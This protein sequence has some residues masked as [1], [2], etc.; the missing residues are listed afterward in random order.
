MIICNMSL[1]VSVSTAVSKLNRRVP[2]MQP[3]FEAISN[4]LEAGATNIDVDFESAADTQMSIEGEETLCNPKK[5]TGFTITYDGAGFDSRNIKAFTELWTRNKFDLGCK[6]IGR[7]TWLKVYENI[8]I[9]SET[10]EGRTEI[11][12]TKSF[13]PG[14]D[15]K[16][17]QLENRS[18]SA[19]STRISFSGITTD[20]YKPQTSKSPEVDKR[21][22]AELEH[23]HSLVENHLLLKLILLKKEGRSFNI[24][25]RLNTETV[26]ISD[27]NIPILTEEDFSIQNAS[28]IDVSFALHYGFFDNG[29]NRQY[30]YYC[31]N[32]RAVKSFRNNIGITGFP[33]KE[34]AIML[35]VS[36]YLDENV[37]DERNG[38]YFE[39]DKDGEPILGIDTIE[40]V[41]KPRVSKLI[42]DKFPTITKAFE[43]IKAAAIE[44]VPY[45]ASII[46]KED[47]IFSTKE[48]VITNAE[49]KFETLKKE[50]TKNFLK[51]LKGKDVKEEQFAQGIS[52]VS[53]VALAELGEY[54]FYR[55][56]IIDGLRYAIDDTAK[57][58]KF[59]HDIFMPMGSDDAAEKGRQYQSNLWLLDDKFMTYSYAASNKTLNQIANI[60]IPN[61]TKT[62]SAGNRKKPDLSI[63]FNKEVDGRAI[64]VEFKGANAS[65]DEKNKSITELPN[66]IDAARK[67]LNIPK[68][69]PIWGYIITTIDKEFRRTLNNQKGYVKLFS[70]S[71]K[72]EAY[73]TF[74]DSE[75]VNA[76]ITVLDLETIISDA[77][78]RNKTFLDILKKR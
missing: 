55:Q 34:S 56:S 41:L 29:K 60:L 35:L 1:N 66:N 13:D 15:I 43:D 3:V 21:E 72:G 2:F 19:N 78:D 44:D 76:H 26:V 33:N 27:V 68:A 51:L 7:L 4:S 73:Y 24:T 40:R 36:K 62:V 67:V 59:I 54:I 71:D 53:E 46:R 12:F 18:N 37:N 39:D 69:Q 11:S 30:F 31:A 10:G 38:F 58:E 45:L 22:S 17:T 25:L 23:L 57:K 47:A 20:Y 9:E 6:G 32:G 70:G 61:Y 42:T 5:V 48:N 49:R 28:G 65:I 52:E 74:N 63:F 77:S 14:Q 64:F 50:S 8:H 75:N 16:C